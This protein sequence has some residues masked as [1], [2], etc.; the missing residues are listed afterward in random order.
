MT[1][2]VIMAVSFLALIFVPPLLVRISE[3]LEARYY[4]P[5]ALLKLFVIKL[6]S[7]KRKSTHIV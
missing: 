5:S 1:F 3:S 7:R 2:G 6:F 4:T